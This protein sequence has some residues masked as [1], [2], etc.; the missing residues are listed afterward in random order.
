MFLEF[1]PSERPVL[2]SH[3][4]LVLLEGYPNSWFNLSLIKPSAYTLGFSDNASFVQRIQCLFSTHA[5][6][7]H[8]E[9]SKTK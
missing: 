2:A 9:T 5:I 7:S 8:T 6:S 4:V 1:D 3:N